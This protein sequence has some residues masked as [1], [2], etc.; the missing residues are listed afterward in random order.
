MMGEQV[1]PVA[2]V[3]R[4]LVGNRS[5]G[6]TSIRQGGLGPAVAMVGLALF[7][8][9]PANEA[10]AA[11]APAA[12]GAT[13]SNTTVNCNGVVTNQNAPDGYGTGGQSNDVV[14]VQT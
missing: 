7:L 1:G 3:W 13:P 11:C 14:N 8:T 6:G 4:R 5:C 9:W 12:V 2:L 10:L